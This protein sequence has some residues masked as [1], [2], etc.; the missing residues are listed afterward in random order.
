MTIKSEVKTLKKK[1]IPIADATTT[2]R[3]WVHISFKCK[4]CNTVKDVS[5]LKNNKSC[6]IR[7]K[8]QQTTQK[9][10]IE[11]LMRRKNFTRSVVQYFVLRLVIKV[12]I[13]LCI[14]PVHLFCLCPSH[15]PS[16]RRSIN[17][18][19]VCKV[20]CKYYMY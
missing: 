14:L 7:T 11:K 13:T 6:A 12:L 20:Y 15:K 9:T 5:N 4:L 10:S 2:N 1:M 18:C 19:T 17:I 16:F 3:Y 8:V